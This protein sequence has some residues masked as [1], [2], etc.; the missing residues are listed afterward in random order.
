MGV[1]MYL[2][3]AK[4]IL[5]S[6]YHEHYAQ[7]KNDYQ[8]AFMDE[9]IKHSYQVLGA[10]NFILNH[11]SCFADCSA[12]EKEYLQAMVLL[13]DVARFYEIL[14]VGEGRGFDHGVYGA[15]M[16]SLIPEFNAVEIILPIKHH[17]HLIEALYDDEEYKVLPFDVQE[18]VRRNAFLVRDADKLANFYLLASHYETVRDVFFVS[19]KY[20]S[21]YDKSPSFEMLER[22][23]A[24]SSS[25]PVSFKKNFADEALLICAWVYDLNYNASFEFMKRLRIVPKLFEH[26]SQY[27]NSD[28]RL[29]YEQTMQEYIRK[30]LEI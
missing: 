1:Y 20:I 28:D 9:K 3:K 22:Y 10:G 4:K 19:K 24:Y 6:E 29:K 30:R 8:M 14:V 18:K 5:E 2:A 23:N 25:I 12:E 11:E 17:G 21:P 15:K 7:Y 16:L 13:H 27:W 26:F